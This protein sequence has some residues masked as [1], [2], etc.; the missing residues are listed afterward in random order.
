MKAE[1]CSES[2]DALE[3]DITV[4]KMEYDK[5]MVEVDSRI[6]LMGDAKI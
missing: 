2:Y 4:F 6:A 3:D 5:R 1:R